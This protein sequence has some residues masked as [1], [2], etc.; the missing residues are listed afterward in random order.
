MSTYI[1]EELYPAGWTV[2]AIS[3]GGSDN[4]TTVRWF[5]LDNTNRV[6]TYVIT[7]PAL[8][9]GAAAFS[10]TIDTDGPGGFQSAS[11][12]G[13]TSYD[14]LVPLPHP[15]DTTVGGLG[16]NENFIIS[17]QEILAYAAAFLADDGTKFPGVT[18]NRTAYVLRGAAI[19]LANSQSRYEDV[20]TAAPVDDPTHPARW[21]EL[22]DI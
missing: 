3:N 19:F 6:M 1:V 7:P 14:L 16:G 21:Q 2:G 5:F 8:E 11:I 10:G 20:G 15:A 9:T 17:T 13:A 22:S 4:G 18:V 12:G